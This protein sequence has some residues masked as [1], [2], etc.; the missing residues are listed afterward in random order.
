MNFNS[1]TKVKDIA[2]SSPAARRVLEDAGLDYCCG[3]SKSLH[4]A[5]LRADVSS[6]EILSRLRENSKSNKSGDLQWTGAPLCEL[7][8]HIRDKHHQ[9]VREAIRSTQTLLD[10]VIQKHGGLTL[11]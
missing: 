6:E 8:R 1:E 5:C 4:E 3:G 10:Q 11:S 2:L 9:Y 7:T